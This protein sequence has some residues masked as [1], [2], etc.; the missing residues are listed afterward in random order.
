MPRI[1]SLYDFISYLKVTFA[2]VS[3]TSFS[4]RNSRKYDDPA[5]FCAAL[6]RSELCRI[7]TKEK[8]GKN[9]K[10]YEIDRSTFAPV[11]EANNG[12]KNQAL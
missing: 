12:R 6:T 2:D 7:T 3:W 11:L 1:I 4:S 9:T 10:T 5:M 8:L